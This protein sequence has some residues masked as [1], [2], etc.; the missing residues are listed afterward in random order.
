MIILITGGIKSGK[1]R[2]A[3]DIAIQEWRVSPAAPVS[4]IATAE[5][6]DG[7]MKLRIKKHQEERAVIG[8]VNG[9]AQGFITI[10]EPL[11]LDRV[12]S[13]AGQRAVVDCLPMWVNNIMYY[14][15]E[16]DFS[17][18]LD[19]F[20]GGMKDCIVVTNETGL[21]NVPFDETTRR[22]NLLLAE[23]N[24]KIAFAADRVEFMI[25]GIPMRV[26]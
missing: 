1:S 22:Y 3:L 16:D 25:S 20:I 12:I 5:A 2:R 21:G 11:E 23:A 18:I 9:G 13:G 7:E 6:L 4:F 14:K 8:G 15:R 26:K 19:F 24:R 17:R 10:E